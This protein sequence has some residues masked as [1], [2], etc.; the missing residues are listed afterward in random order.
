MA[1]PAKTHPSV[2]VTRLVAVATAMRAAAPTRAPTVVTTRGPRWSRA[3]PMG[4]PARA[5]T[6]RP[7]ENAAVVVVVEHPVSAVIDGVRT[8]KA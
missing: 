7:A 8:G 6:M 4:M 2:K 3:W 5:E 1:V